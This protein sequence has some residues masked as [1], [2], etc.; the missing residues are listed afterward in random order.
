M[1]DVIKDEAI[2]L[3][4][5]VQ[6]VH[7]EKMKAAPETPKARYLHPDSGGMK[8]TAEKVHQQV[9]QGMESRFA[10]RQGAPDQKPEPIHRE[11]PKVGRND[12]CPCGSGKKFKKCCGGN[13]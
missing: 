5:R 8:K 6:V 1:T 7:E 12:P 10:P 4:F 11:G 3:L 13:E 2:E 9:E